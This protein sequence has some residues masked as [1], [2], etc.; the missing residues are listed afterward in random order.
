MKAGMGDENLSTVVEKLAELITAKGGGPASAGGGAIVPHTEAGQKLELMPN[1][2]KLEGV[3]NY[4]R[5]SRRA[6]L[7]LNTKGLDE[8]VKGETAEPPDKASSEWKKWSATNSLIV[9]WILNSLVPD[10]AASVEALTHASEIWDTLSNLYSG[11]GNMML[12]A[13]IE[14][15]VHDLRQGEKT[16]M[17]YVAELQH[18]WGD[19]DHVDPLELA[20]GEC[21]SA[22]AS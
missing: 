13:E 22:A 18:I 11:K 12:I 2:I 21:M 3:T 19:L 1:D 10:I 15:K 7:I 6:L 17:A 8:R 9:A 16:M 5:W 20:H 4:L 14:D